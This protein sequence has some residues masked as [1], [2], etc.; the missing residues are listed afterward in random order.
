MDDPQDAIAKLWAERSRGVAASDAVHS[1]LREAIVRGHLEPGMRLGEEEFAKRFDVSRTPVREALLRLETEQLLERVPR[2]GL[3]V[4]T[5]TTD[6]ILDLY[7]VRQAVDSQAARLAA[8][9]ASPPEVAELR[10]L[11]EQI[12]IAANEADYARMASLNIQF[13]ESLCRVGRSPLLLTFMQQI[14]DGVRGIPARR[15]RGPVVLRRPCT[16]TRPSSTRSRPNG[17]AGHPNR[18]PP[19]GARR[20]LA[21]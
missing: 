4:A 18:R 11:S 1:T 19:R 2:H 14:H 15:F 17:P 12:R 21:A 13:H 9:H 20:E 7:V 3:V 8:T 6:T 10:W 16:S 5:V